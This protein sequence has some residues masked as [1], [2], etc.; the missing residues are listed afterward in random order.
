MYIGLHVKCPFS[1]SGFNEIWIFWADF[2]KILNYPVS[3]KSFRWQ[4]SC[5]MRTDRHDGASSRYSQFIIH[6]HVLNVVW[7][8]SV[9]TAEKKML[10]RTGLLTAG[11]LERKCNV[12]PSFSRADCLFFYHSVSTAPL[13]PFIS[14]ALLSLK[15]SRS[16]TCFLWRHLYTCHPLWPD[17]RLGSVPRSHVCNP[18]FTLWKAQ[19]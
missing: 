19:N 5:S 17:S 9:E 13:F 2:R 8:G 11:R 10:R 3:W 6:S 4:P 1:V 12:H 14:E 18:S 15:Q 16:T 7:M